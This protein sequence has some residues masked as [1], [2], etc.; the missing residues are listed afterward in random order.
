MAARRREIPQGGPMVVTRSPVLSKEEKGRLFHEYHRL[1]RSVWEEMFRFPDELR[2]AMGQSG[3]SFQSVDLEE[4]RGVEDGA[5]MMCK[6]D[7]CL[8]SARSILNAWPEGAPRFRIEGFWLDFCSVRNRILEGNMRL[9]V[10]ISKKYRDHGVPF[11]D[12]I[13]DGFFGLR[14]AVDL[15]DPSRG[16]QFSTYG[17]WWIKAT[18]QRSIKNKKSIVRVPIHIQESRDMVAKAEGEGGDCLPSVSERS[19]KVLHFGNVIPYDADDLGKD[20]PTMADLIPGSF[21]RDVEAS[22]FISESDCCADYLNVER[23]L[24]MRH[25]EVAIDRLP[26]RERDIL[27]RRFGIR[28]QEESTLQDIANKYN[29]SRERVRQIQ[30]QAIR[31]VRASIERYQDSVRVGLR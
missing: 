15:F 4:C 11:E 18:V 28:D 24:N 8:D 29:I 12:I 17:S 7:A 30:N 22:S 27:T 25:V 20:R 5:L 23:S 9:V 14:R 31:A 3:V 6:D 2:R 13:Q 16:I 26:E 10:R 21:G 1:K 19:K